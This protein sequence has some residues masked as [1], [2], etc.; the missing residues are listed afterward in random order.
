MF[1]WDL[2]IRWHGYSD[3]KDDS[4]H[5]IEITKILVKAQFRPPASNCEAVG[6]TRQSYMQYY[7]VF[8]TAL[9]KSGAY[10]TSTY[11]EI[12]VNSEEADGLSMEDW[13]KVRTFLRI[14]TGRSP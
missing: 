12:Y 5:S 11:L 7:N 2:Q 6:R 10:P 13:P 1:E 14:A 3:Y 8:V 9:V 4:I